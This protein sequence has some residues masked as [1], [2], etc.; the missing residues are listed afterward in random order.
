MS[1]LKRKP[2][3]KCVGESFHADDVTDASPRFSF[4]DSIKIVS[5]FQFYLD[6]LP[7]SFSFVIRLCL[8]IF[9]CYIYF[10]SN[11]WINIF[12]ILGFYRNLTIK[13]NFT[14]L[15][16]LLFIQTFYSLPL[17]VISITEA[18]FLSIYTILD[19][20]KVLIWIL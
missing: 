15:Y 8:S 7:L 14:I 11:Q 19:I 4:L 12:M 6:S 5:C 20:F 18:A 16:C 1:W 3:L 9:F 13:K 17:F 10:T 2:V